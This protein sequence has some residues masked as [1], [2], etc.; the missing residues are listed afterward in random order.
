MALIKAIIT[1]GRH[2][3]YSISPRFLSLSPG[4]RDEV[5]VL[6]EAGLYESEEA[7][8]AD[9][10]ARWEKDYYGFRQDVLDLL[11]T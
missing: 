7:F 6:T 3:K 9:V 11:L 1:R 5:A 4:L 8:L 2:G 10:Y